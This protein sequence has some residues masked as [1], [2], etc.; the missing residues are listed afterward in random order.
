MIIS[1]QIAI[2]SIFLSVALFS[3]YEYKNG[4]L[5]Q[6]ATNYDNEADLDCDECCT[7]PNITISAGHYITPDTTFVAD[8]IL[9]NNFNQKYIIKSAYFVLNDFQFTIDDQTIQVIDTF[10][11]SND[12]NEDMRFETDD[13]II[14]RNNQVL[15]TV[16]MI[17]EV[18][19][20]SRIQC[21]LGV[22]DNC[23]PSDNDHILAKN[24]SLFANNLFTHLVINIVHGVELDQKR[25]FKLQ[26]DDEVIQIDNNIE[27]IKS[28][29]TPTN[30]NMIIRYD[31]VLNHIDFE[32]DTHEDFVDVVN[33]TNNFISFKN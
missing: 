11:C 8:T 30:I 3:C 26:G 32:N 1:K 29:R 23:L 4:C 28:P 14:A 10:E 21:Q 20:L 17:R 12:E 27:I 13:Y 18:G 31:Q 19:T 6:L 2:L 25:S 5:D 9:E 22:T 16:G 24:D 7:Y 15:H 33:N